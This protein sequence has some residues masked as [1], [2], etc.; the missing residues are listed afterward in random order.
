MIDII[1]HCW[2]GVIDQYA[3]LLHYQLNSVAECLPES[4]KVRFNVCTAEEDTLTRGIV[5]M[6]RE[7]VEI[8]EHLFDVPD[9]MRRAIGRHQVA[10]DLSE[11]SEL[12]W[13]ADC[14]YLFG[15]GCLDTLYAKNQTSASVIWP[16]YALTNTTHA[17]G[18]GLVL[19]A[20]AGDVRMPPESLFYPKRNRA[21]IG[22]I[23]ITQSKIAREA[24]YMQEG[25]R[26]LKPVPDGAWRRTK[27]DPR[28][29]K[30]MRA[31][32]TRLRL[33]LP[34]LYRIRHTEC[35]REVAKEQL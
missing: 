4:V 17:I 19:N 13:F 12:V 5:E 20:K 30:Y 26:W 11:D 25:S 1:T 10:L 6:M 32:G 14:D 22:G 34:N 9:L 15:E 21:A 3:Y 31:Y 2:S 28:W 33:E 29:R 8:R 35:G 7:K 23:Q 27:E 16:S 18:D 24:G